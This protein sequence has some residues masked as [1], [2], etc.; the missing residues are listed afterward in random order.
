MIL[1]M[2]ETSYRERWTIYV[3]PDCGAREEDPPTGCE[4][5][6][7]YGIALVPVEVVPAR[8]KGDGSKMGEGDGAFRCAQRKT[9]RR[10]GSDRDAGFP[11]WL[12]NESMDE[13]WVLADVASTPEEAREFVRQQWGFEMADVAE[14]VVSDAPLPMCSGVGPGPEGPD[15][16]WF[17]PCDEKDAE[18]YYWRLAP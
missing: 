6:E 13:A 8:T 15:T 18:V 1:S 10:V 3:C 14:Y 9:T 4:A 5:C 7:T 11:E 17:K 2:S 12:E 16:E